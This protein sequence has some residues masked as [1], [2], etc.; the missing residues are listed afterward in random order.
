MLAKNMENNIL[1]NS[2]N[3]LRKKKISKIN[4]VTRLEAEDYVNRCRAAGLGKDKVR[5]APP[6]FNRMDPEKFF[7]PVIT[8]MVVLSD[9]QFELRGKLLLT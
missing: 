7:L 2:R 5:I 3:W 9:F 4:R 8:N 1:Q 6:H